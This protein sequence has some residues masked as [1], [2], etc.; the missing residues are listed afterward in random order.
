MSGIPRSQFP[1]TGKNSGCGYAASVDLM[2][3]PPGQG[4]PQAPQTLGQRKSVAHIPT[5]TTAAAKDFF[6]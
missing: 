2:G 5:T 3:N 1:A 6:P 4:Y